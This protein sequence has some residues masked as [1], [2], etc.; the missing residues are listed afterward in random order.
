MD[1]PIFHYK[2]NRPD[3]KPPL[4]AHVD[5]TG[6]DLTLLECVKRFGLVEM[7][8]TGISVA[9]ANGYYFD[10]V[11]RSSIIKSGYILANGIG[12]ID[13]GYRGSILVPL[14]KIDKEAEKLKLP[15]ALVQLVPRKRIDLVPLETED[16]FSG[17]SRGDGGFGSTNK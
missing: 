16:F 11:A 2:L 15:C 9:P 1:F 14:I 6:F 8:D 4:K 10:L 17:T 12:I 3:A 13:S 7:Y 5:D